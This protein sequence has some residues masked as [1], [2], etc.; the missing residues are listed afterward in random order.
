MLSV[1]SSYHNEQDIVHAEREM[2]FSGLKCSCKASG[3]E[4]DPEDLLTPD[5]GQEAKL[6]GK[7]MRG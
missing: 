4:L 6:C 2:P 5:Q 3:P 1:N 7:G